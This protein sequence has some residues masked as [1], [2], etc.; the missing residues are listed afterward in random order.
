MS[1]E[2]QPSDAGEQPDDP[3]TSGHVERT[4]LHTMAGD[5]DEGLPPTTVGGVLE[6]VAAV[7]ER[8][9]YGNVGPRGGDGRPLV[10]QSTVRRTF[11][12]LADK[13]LV[14]RV[15]D[16]SE[17]ELRDGPVD[18]G[19]LSEGGDPADPADYAETADDA[20]ITDW[21]LTE[22]GRRE[23]DRLDERYAAELDDLAARYGRPRGETTER[24]EA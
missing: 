24:V 6:D 22:E 9:G 13:G 2:T 11:G 18:L 21:Y 10:Q 12:Q 23:V 8:G 17:A 3:R 15:E 7:V 19:E 20:R 4:V 14:G 16:L 1:N 5:G